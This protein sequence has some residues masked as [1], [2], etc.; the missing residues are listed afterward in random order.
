MSSIPA[1]DLTPANV[2]PF[3]A[4]VSL[5]RLTQ[6]HFDTFQTCVAEQQ[7][8][9][10]RQQHDAAMEKLAGVCDEVQLSAH[11]LT[12]GRRLAENTTLAANR[13]RNEL[14]DVH[15]MCMAIDRA[16]A[17]VDPGASC[18]SWLLSWRQQHDNGTAAPAPALALCAVLADALTA[19]CASIFPTPQPL[20]QPPHM[21]SPMS[22]PLCL[23]HG[24]DGNSLHVP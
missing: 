5:A 23:I 11:R 20:Q 2:V 19:L 3:D 6:Q 1:E 9:W 8:A 15:K 22:G 4:V 7:N 13:R 14:A 18:G 21:P 10:L 24:P 12:L 16:N 17:P